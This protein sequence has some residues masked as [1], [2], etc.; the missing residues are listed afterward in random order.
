MFTVL[1]VSAFTFVSCGSD[2]DGGSSNTCQTCSEYTVEVDGQTQT[3]PAIEVCEGE[4][5]NAFI[6]S[7]DTGVAFDSYIQTQE[8]V[9]DCN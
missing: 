2:D 1:V 7:E 4:N 5:G 6:S 9:R 3:V 8:L